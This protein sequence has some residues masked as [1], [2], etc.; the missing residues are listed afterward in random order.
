V[1]SPLPTETT[2]YVFPYVD[3]PGTA[4]TPEY[5]GTHCVYPFGMDPTWFLAENDILTVQDSV[6]MK[7]SVIIAVLHMSIGIVLK[8]L[9]MRFVKNWL[10]FWTEVVT[11]F[12]IL[13]GLFGWMDFLIIYKWLWPMNP[14]STAPAM[15][16]R[17]TS[18]PSIITVMIN[19]LLAGGNQPYVNATGSYEIYMFPAQK[20]VSEMLVYIVLICI[21]IMLCVKPCSAICCPH[22]MGMETHHDVREA[23]MNED[24]QNPN[25]DYNQLIVNKTP[26]I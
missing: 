26:D 3:F 24:S 1:V 20:T 14:Y 6:K 9:N 17:I 5:D 15:V 10:V 22:F 25:G 19:N 13:N 7:I 11:G 23:Q 2:G 4:T 12:L 16:Q 8:G 18:A 21:P